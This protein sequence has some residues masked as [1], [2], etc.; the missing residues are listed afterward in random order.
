MK[1]FSPF[2]QAML[3]PEECYILDNGADGNIFVWKGV[4]RLVVDF[5]PNHRPRRRI[6]DRGVPVEG[7]GNVSVSDPNRS[8]GQPARA[9]RSHVYRSEVHQRQGLL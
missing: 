1:E 6:L 3:S 2:K 9:Q 4:S 8:K 7:N 5:C